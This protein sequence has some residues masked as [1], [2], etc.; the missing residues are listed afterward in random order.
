[1]G[2]HTESFVCHPLPPDRKC[3]VL[4]SFLFSFSHTHLCNLC[5]CARAYYSR[6]E[7]SDKHTCHG[8]GQFISSSLLLVQKKEEALTDRID[9]SA[10]FCLLLC[11]PL[12]LSV[13]LLSSLCLISPLIFL[14]FS[15]GLGIALLILA[16]QFPRDLKENATTDEEKV[17]NE[18]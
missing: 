4:F 8:S 9:L 2:Q 11:V 15:Q 1:M 13:C 3:V 17:R 10:S 7:M 6:E 18:E 14:L 5:E 12:S 16:F